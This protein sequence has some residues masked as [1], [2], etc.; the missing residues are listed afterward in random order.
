MYKALSLVWVLQTMASI[1]QP[2]FPILKLLCQI[3]KLWLTIQRNVFCL[4]WRSSLSLHLLVLNYIIVT[5]ECT[6]FNHGIALTCALDRIRDSNIIS[7]HFCAVVTKLEN[8]SVRSTRPKNT[9]KPPTT[10][11]ENQVQVSSLNSTECSY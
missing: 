4:D 2:T 7:Q 10:S 8:G 6:Y 3:P 11:D 9:D 1:P 5:Y